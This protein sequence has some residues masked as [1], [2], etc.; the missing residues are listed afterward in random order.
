MYKCAG[1]FPGSR[2]DYLVRYV[3]HLSAGYLLEKLCIRY[4]FKLTDRANKVYRCL[5]CE[6]KA[7]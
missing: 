2:I 1:S 7:N 3:K 4:I 5:Y 6:T